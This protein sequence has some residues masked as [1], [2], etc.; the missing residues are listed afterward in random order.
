MQHRRP[1][2][3]MLLL[4]RHWLWCP[5]MLKNTLPKESIWDLEHG[6]WLGEQ[7]EATV[8]GPEHEHEEG[9]EHKGTEPFSDWPYLV[10]AMG[11]FGSPVS[12]VDY[13]E[14]RLRPFNKAHNRVGL[15]LRW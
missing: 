13:S 1:Y 3:P 14:G 7:E 2:P 5:D 10:A 6:V 15:G 12:K 8:V 9:F 4:H 11:Y